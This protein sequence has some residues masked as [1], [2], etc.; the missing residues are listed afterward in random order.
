MVGVGLQLTKG[1]D[2]P[3]PYLAELGK[4]TG[5]TIAAACMFHSAT[6]P[7]ASVKEMEMID[8]A[9]AD[10]VSIWGQVSPAPLNMEF[11]LLSPYPFEG[12]ESWRIEAMSVV[13]QPEAYRAVLSDPA[14]RAKPQTSALHN[15]ALQLL[16]E[17]TIFSLQVRRSRL[18]STASTRAG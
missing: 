4:Q 17:L 12:L 14:F 15:P 9:A 11:Q 18:R 1:P 7:E 3:I 10:G 6:S 16:T 8:A 2:T 13:N 5:R